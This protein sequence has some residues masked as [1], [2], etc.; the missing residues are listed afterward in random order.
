MS[1]SLVS[2][3]VFTLMPNLAISRPAST[4]SWVFGRTPTFRKTMSASRVSPEASCTPVTRPSLPTM[5]ST[6]SPVRNL[7]PLPSRYSRTTALMSPSSM[8]GSG[9]SMSSTMVMV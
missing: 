6:F 7:S 3:K 2:W 8:S 5:R 9:R 1:G 4:A